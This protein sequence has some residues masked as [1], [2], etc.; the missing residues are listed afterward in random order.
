MKIVSCL[1]GAAMMVSALLSVPAAAES[2]APMTKKEMQ[3]LYPTTQEIYEDCKA[4]VKLYETDKKGFMNSS[5]AARINGVLWGSYLVA[6]RVQAYYPED[7]DQNC[8]AETQRTRQQVLTAVQNSLCVPTEA[9]PQD[10]PLE[11][12]IANDVVKYI[13]N[14]RAK[15]IEHSQYIMAGLLENLYRCKKSIKEN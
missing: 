10:R 15:N 1:G 11:L 13:E 7:S 6:G 2:D 9:F 4:A 12:S 5:C 14:N 8:A 3:A